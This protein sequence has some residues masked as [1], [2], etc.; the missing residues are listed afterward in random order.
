MRRFHGVILLRV[1][2]PTADEINEWL[3]SEE[4]NPADAGDATHFRRIGAAVTSNADQAE[5]EAAV[6][7]ARDCRR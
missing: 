7:A 5:L 2:D 3:D 6:A 4:I 1:V